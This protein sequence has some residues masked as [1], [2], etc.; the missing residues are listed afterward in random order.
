M[1]MLKQVNPWGCGLYAVANALALDNFVTNDRLERSKYGNTVGQLSRWLQDDGFG[2]C[3]DSLY[4]NYLGK[5]LPS[6]ALA[7]RPSHGGFLV[8]VLL[9]VRFSDNGKNH[10]VGG[11]IEN[12]GTFHLYDSLKD[13]V[14]ITTLKK[15]NTMYHNV[16][17]LFVFVGVETGDYVYLQNG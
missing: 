4:Y 11:V 7:Y 2:L 15:V 16:Y 1:G 9:N 3:I 5:K 13:G 17:G 8:P 12:D 10:M 14:C 6:T